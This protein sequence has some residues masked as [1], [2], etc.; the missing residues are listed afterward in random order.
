MSSNYLS[1]Y[2]IKVINKSREITKSPSSYKV[3]PLKISQFTFTI[4]YKKIGK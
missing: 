4:V 1:H 3:I 2:H